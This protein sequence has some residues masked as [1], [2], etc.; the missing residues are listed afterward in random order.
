MEGRAQTGRSTRCRSRPSPPLARGPDLLEHA[1]RQVELFVQDDPWIHGQPRGVERDPLSR[2]ATSATSGIDLARRHVDGEIQGAARALD[3]Q[4]V[5][6]SD[7][8][9]V[10][11]ARSPLI[12]PSSPGEVDELVGVSRC[13]SRSRTRTS[14]STPDLAGIQRDDGLVEDLEAIPHRWRHVNPR[15]PPAA[16]RGPHSFRA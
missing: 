1:D 3:F 6:H 5:G 12:S 15:L 16:G 10:R 7:G 8:P 4:H 14:A 2:P 9:G 11:G 13:P